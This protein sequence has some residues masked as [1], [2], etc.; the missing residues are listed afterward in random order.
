MTV[1]RR[2]L[3]DPLPPADLVLRSDCHPEAG[4]RRAVIGDQAW[5][6]V[7]PLA[8]GRRLRLEMG[9]RGRDAMLAMLIDETVDDQIEEIMGDGNL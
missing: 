2:P 6:F 3:G 9:R 8:D 1:E 7:I 5:A 4:G